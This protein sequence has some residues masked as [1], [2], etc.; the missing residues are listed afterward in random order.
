MVKLANLYL[1]GLFTIYVQF[2]P[3]LGETQ[4]WLILFAIFCMMIRDSGIKLDR[5]DL[6]LLILIIIFLSVGIIF[7]IIN[8]VFDFETFF[9]TIMF[10]FITWGVAQFKPEDVSVRLINTFIIFTCLYGLLQFLNFTAIKLLNE[11]LFVRGA[12]AANLRGI[13]LFAPEQSY[14]GMILITLFFIQESCAFKYS[15]KLVLNSNRIVIFVL[16]VVLKSS[17]CL[18]FAVL[19]F[20]YLVR[21]SFLRNSVTLSTAAFI[22]YLWDDRIL[23]IVNSIF[24][25]IDSF[26]DAIV[27]ILVIEPSATIRIITSILA[28]KVFLNN[29]LGSGFGYFRVNWLSYISEGTILTNNTLL[30]RSI[31][32]GQKLFVQSA[33]LNILSDIGILFILVLILFLYKTRHTH[34]FF[35]NLFTLSTLLIFVF[36]QHGYLAPFIGFFIALARKQEQSDSNIRTVDKSL[37]NVMSRKPQVPQDG[38]RD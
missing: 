6:I 20:L 37:P 21:G 26:G 7:S 22:T 16:L 8:A 12:A 27:A 30:Q 25:R 1:I 14:M 31:D 2:I 9:K 10:L 38:T 33:P 19:I 15:S 29:A 24:E 36:Y 18:L 5:G 13:S 23:N 28:F 34:N 11:A 17:L 4:P 3:G 32:K 35:S